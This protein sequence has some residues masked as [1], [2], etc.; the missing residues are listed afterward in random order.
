MRQNL[1]ASGLPH[2]A[3]RYLAQYGFKALHPDGQTKSGWPRMIQ[4]LQALNAACWPPLPPREFLRL[5]YDTAGTP[6]RYED[7][8]ERSA[9]GW[10]WQIT[11]EAAHACQ[12]NTDEYSYL[13]DQLTEWT[14][15]A[16]HYKLSPYKNQRRKGIEWLELMSDATH[17]WRP[18]KSFPYGLCGCL[19]MA[20]QRYIH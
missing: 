13:F 1:L 20:G 16:R 8:G 11:C 18:K 7:M 14:W 17:I 10:F 15:M 5:H 6:Q 12:G 4:T 9:A 3:W 2:R 19:P